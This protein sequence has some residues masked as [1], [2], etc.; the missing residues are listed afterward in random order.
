MIDYKVVAEEPWQ[1]KGIRRM[2]VK[3]YYVYF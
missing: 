1:S 2:R 3:N